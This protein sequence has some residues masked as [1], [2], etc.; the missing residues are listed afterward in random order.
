MRRTH[1]H[2]KRLCAADSS[3]LRERF[4]EALHL[5]HGAADVPLHLAAYREWLCERG[6]EP[7]TGRMTAAGLAFFKDCLDKKNSLQT[8]KKNAGHPASLKKPYFIRLL[9]DSGE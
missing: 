3:L 4:A 9:A 2:P 5:R 1:N 7:E 8:S 6:I